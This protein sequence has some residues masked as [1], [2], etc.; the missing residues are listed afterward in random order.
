MAQRKRTTLP[1]DFHDLLT[2]ASTDELVAVFDNREV[3]AHDGYGKK[4]ALSFYNCSVDL[5]RWLLEHG[6]DPNTADRGGHTPLHHRGRDLEVMAL[7]LNSGADISAQDHVGNTPLHAAARSLDADAVTMLMS[8]GAN[9]HA[10]NSRGQTPLAVALEIATT[11]SLEQA[12]AVAELLR[13]AGAE[14]SAIMR[15]DVESVGRDWEFYRSHGE[16]EPHFAAQEPTLRAL[17]ELVGATPARPHRVHDGISPI[18]VT[19]SDPTDQHQELWGLL[20]PGTGASRTVQ[21]EV[22]R[23]TGRVAIEIN[24]NGGINWDAGFQLMLAALMIHLGTGVPLP[25][26]ALAEARRL[27]V[28]LRTGIG[29]EGDVLRLAELGVQWVLANPDPT[30]LPAP[31][32]RR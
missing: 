17:Y 3:D 21:G 31:S 30:V 25:A 15:G 1:K 2:T 26:P 23:I 29:V 24:E 9:V 32:Y 4:A 10:K 27:A 11:T 19:G 8:R 12:L 28:G 7:L 20:V 6:A 16:N 18:T 13:S 5:A 14:V 22:I